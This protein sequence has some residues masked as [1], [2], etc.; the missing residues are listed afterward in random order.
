MAVRY[1]NQGMGV[2][3]N[4]GMAELVNNRMGVWVNDKGND[5]MQVWVYDGGA[6]GSMGGWQNVNDEVQALELWVLWSY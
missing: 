6:G 2:R 5:R 4:D 3:V 1:W